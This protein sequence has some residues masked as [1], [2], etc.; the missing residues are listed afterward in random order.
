MNADHILMVFTN[1]NICFLEAVLHKM[2]KLWAKLLRAGGK[3]CHLRGAGLRS[4]FASMRHR[5]M[6]K[7]WDI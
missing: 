4:T 1:I 5:E 3:Q 2:P 7:C 6:A